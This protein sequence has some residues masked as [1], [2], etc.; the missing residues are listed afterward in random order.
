MFVAERTGY[1]QKMTM[2]QK[3][4]G[5]HQP[6]FSQ[7]D[8]YRQSNSTARPPVNRQ[9]I[10]G[11]GSQPVRS[12]A[13]SASGNSSVTMRPINGGNRRRKGKGGRSGLKKGLIIAGA[14]LSVV[15]I[16]I[17]IGTIWMK[18]HLL[19]QINYET[20]NQ[21]MIDEDG[22][23]VS[24]SDLATETTIYSP[25][26]EEGIE[27]ILLIGIDS[28]S[29][30]YSKDGT[31]NLADIIMILTVNKND[32]TMKLTSIQRDC[33]AYIPGYSEPKKINAAMSYGGPELLKLVIQNSLRLDINQYAYVDIGHME[34]IVDA[35]GGVTVNVS[36]S[37]RTAAYGLNDLVKVQNLN[38][39]DPEGS[40]ML[41]ESG[42]VTLDGRQ[43]VSYA[44][45]RHVGNGDYERS[46]RQVEVL[47]SLMKSYM[48]LD[49]TKKVDVLGE[50]LSLIS[51]NMTKSEI[52]DYVYNFLP[53]LTST[54]LEYMSVPAAGYS[55]E[56]MYGTEW[57]IRPNWN[58]MVPL[59]Q[60][61]IFGKTFPYDK[62]DAIPEAPVATPTPVPAGDE[63]KSGS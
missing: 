30:S 60:Q 54:K 28:R 57:S 53:K 61:Y 15:I 21:T 42:L 12:R 38:V 41:D 5:S 11:T 26:E 1:E 58:G 6:G 31:G 13:Q 34:K 51:T 63:T 8:P 40:H 2:K 50:V 23:V 18:D 43:A 45:I 35:V 48:E 27:N 29:K 47:T 20:G 36:E 56:G 25:P 37:E 62:V 7:Y 52:E 49:L 33:Y 14:I 4:T 55:N 32:N 59:V 44:R 39:G 3:N 46:E 22:S 16:A 19:D 9:Q 10:R 24:I 17:V